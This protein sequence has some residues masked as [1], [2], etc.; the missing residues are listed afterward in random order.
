MPK[1]A[2]HGTT[3]LTAI[4]LR[5]KNLALEIGLLRLIGSGANGAVQEFTKLARAA[6]PKIVRK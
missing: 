4:R 6:V 5:G 3:D 1:V 2:L